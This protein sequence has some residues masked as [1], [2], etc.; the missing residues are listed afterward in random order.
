ME[1]WGLQVVRPASDRVWDAM[2]TGLECTLLK[3]LE[4]G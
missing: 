4:E 3:Q 1:C 2:V